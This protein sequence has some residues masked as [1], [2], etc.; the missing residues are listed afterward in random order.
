MSLEAVGHYLVAKYTP[1]N[2]GGKFGEPL[3][4]VSKKF[5]QSK[6]LFYNL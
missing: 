2:E 6:S 5:V 3:Y 1:V 4:A